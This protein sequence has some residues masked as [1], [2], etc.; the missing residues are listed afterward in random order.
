[1]AQRENVVSVGAEWRQVD[2]T[3]H[4]DGGD[5]E[6]SSSFGVLCLPLTFYLLHIPL[7]L[8]IL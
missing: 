6:A 4:Q 7:Y 8:Y 2:T 1:M 5:L 3:G